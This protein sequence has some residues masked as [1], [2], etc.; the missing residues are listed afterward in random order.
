MV[1]RINR[2][3]LRVSLSM[4]KAISIVLQGI[5]AVIIAFV[6]VITLINLGVLRQGSEYTSDGS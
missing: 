4:R 2:A 6:I 3:L 5:L 1:D